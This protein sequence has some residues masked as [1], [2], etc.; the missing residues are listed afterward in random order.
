MDHVKELVQSIRANG[1]LLDPLLVRDGDNVVLEGNSRLAAYRLLEKENPVKWGEVKCDVVPRAVGDGQ[2]FALLTQYHIVGRKDWAPFEQAGV[3]W[4]RWREE[5]RPKEQVADEALRLGLTVSRVMHMMDVYDFMV[6]HND[7]SQSHW[8]YYDEYFKSRVIQKVRKNE[9]N[10][11]KV[12]VGKI[13]SHEIERADDIRKKVTKIAKVGNKTLKKFIKK[14]N[15]LNDCYDHARSQGAENVWLQ[16][17]DKFQKFIQGVEIK[18]SLENMPK[19]QRN[20][21]KY[22]VKRIHRR[23]KDILDHI[24]KMDA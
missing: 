10:F 13:R 5:G 16:R 24:E 19:R 17:L 23:T 22:S 1:G 7:T 11:D 20:K 4:R 12:I 18:A 9:K 14:I 21:C 3:F 8:S 6:E 2:I 15:S